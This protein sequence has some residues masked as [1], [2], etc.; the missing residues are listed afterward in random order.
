[1]TSY[2]VK[3]RASALRE[4]I[5]DGAYKCAPMEWPQE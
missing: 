2:A 4:E 1:M 5:T 3:Q